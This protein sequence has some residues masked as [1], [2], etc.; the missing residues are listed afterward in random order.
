MISFRHQLRGLVSCVRYLRAIS[1]KPGY[2]RFGSSAVRV[3]DDDEPDVEP[4]LELCDSRSPSS[5]LHEPLQ[6]VTGEY[7]ES[8]VELDIIF[9]CPPIVATNGVGDGVPPRLPDDPNKRSLF[10]VFVFV[11]VRE[12]ERYEE[13]PRFICVLCCF[14]CCFFSI[15]FCPPRPP[16]FTPTP[17]PTPPPP[18]PPLIAKPLLLLV[19]TA[20]ITAGGPDID[21]SVVVEVCVEPPANN[22]G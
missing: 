20:I 9:E 13:E 21:N 2:C 5:E 15:T 7:V 17:P 1:G 14:C 3:V 18:P 10:F 16:L 11:F 6:L 22:E 12:D 4:S 8:P 19:T